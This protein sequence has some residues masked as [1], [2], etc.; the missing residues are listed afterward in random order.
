MSCARRAN[1][2]SGRSKRVCRAII[3]PRATGERLPAHHRAVYA[4]SVYSGDGI[5][6]DKDNRFVEIIDARVF[7]IGHSL[8]LQSAR[9]E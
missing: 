1:L 2:P 5:R 8:L 7:S 3:A 4:E 6:Y 9:A